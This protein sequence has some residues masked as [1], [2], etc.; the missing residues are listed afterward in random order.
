M[1]AIVRVRDFPGLRRHIMLLSTIA[2]I[3]ELCFQLRE[4]AHVEKDVNESESTQWNRR[5]NGVKINQALHSRLPRYGA[6]LGK[7]SN[8]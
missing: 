1:P 3:S 4:G 2:S 5:W 8:Y 6:E 7:C